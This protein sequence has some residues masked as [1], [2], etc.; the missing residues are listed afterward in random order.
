[1]VAA[2]TALQVELAERMAAAVVAVAVHKTEAA[3]AE[4]AERTAVAAVAAT[5]AQVELAER[6][7]APAVGLGHPAQTALLLMMLLL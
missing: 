3:K 6:M 7:A 2:H 1:M 4:L 5:K